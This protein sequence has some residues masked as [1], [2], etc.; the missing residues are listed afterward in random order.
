M[1][2]C[3]RLHEY[4]SDDIATRHCFKFHAVDTPTIYVYC[5]SFQ[6]K[7]LIQVCFGILKGSRLIYESLYENTFISFSCNRLFQFKQ[8][9][10]EFIKSNMTLTSYEKCLSEVT[11]NYHK[12]LYV[13][14]SM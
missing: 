10:N 14:M 7:F 9:Y 8:N 12:I 11:D 13:Y 2:N 1:S 4:K 5:S 3:C 6:N